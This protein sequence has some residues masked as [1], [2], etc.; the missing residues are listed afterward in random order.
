MVS[1]KN[2]N[3]DLVA[4]IPILPL[5]LIFVNVKLHNQIDQK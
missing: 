3:L 2:E 4:E 5:F 1:K